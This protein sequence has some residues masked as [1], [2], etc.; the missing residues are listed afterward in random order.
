MTMVRLGKWDAWRW[1]RLGIGIWVIGQ[2]ISSSNGQLIVMGVFFTLMP[3]LNVGC[4]GSGAC[5]VP[6]SK[7]IHAEQEVRFEEVRSD[8]PVER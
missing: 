6:Q 3:L 8:T 2:G 4:C 1:L 5:G 7:S